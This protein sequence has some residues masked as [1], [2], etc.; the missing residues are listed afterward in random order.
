[1]SSD[2]EIELQRSL[3]RVEGKLDSLIQAFEDRNV[4]SEALSKRVTRLERI[5]AYGA[6]V[7]ATGITIGGFLFGGSHGR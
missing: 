4:A 7:V 3:G 6:G 1:M 5:A 2:T